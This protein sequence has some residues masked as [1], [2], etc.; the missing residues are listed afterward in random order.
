MDEKTKQTEAQEKEKH[1][2]KEYIIILILIPGDRLIACW[3]SSLGQ[4]SVGIWSLFLTQG[5]DKSPTSQ[6]PKAGSLNMKEGVS[7]IRHFISSAS[8]CDLS[9]G[10]CILGYYGPQGGFFM[11]SILMH[12]T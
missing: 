3:V 2:D 7:D 10:S 9:Q 11:V 5:E 4:P 8:G 1:L 6:N 12:S